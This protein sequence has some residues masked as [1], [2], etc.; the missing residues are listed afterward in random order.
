MVQHKSLHLFKQY[1]KNA[2]SSVESHLLEDK[3]CCQRRPCCYTTFRLENQTSVLCHNVNTQNAKIARRDRPLIL[4]SNRCEIFENL[5]HTL[6]WYYF[7]ENSFRDFT[8]KNRTMIFISI[9]SPWICQYKYIY[10]F[11]VVD[12]DTARFS[13]CSAQENCASLVEPHTQQTV[14]SVC[15]Y[16]CLICCSFN[17][18]SKSRESNYIFHSC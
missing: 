3:F 5:L 1:N 8:L 4:A 18:T 15:A 10:S 2:H 17:K 14:N 12:Q 13:I 11:F 9:R 6:Y 7:S 16:S